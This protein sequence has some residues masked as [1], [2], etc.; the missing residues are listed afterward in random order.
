M[1]RGSAIN[2]LVSHTTGGVP[3][4]QRERIGPVP[5]GVH[6]HGGDV[7]EDSLNTSGSR[8][9]FDLHGNDSRI[10]R[11]KVVVVEG[12]GVASTKL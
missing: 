5:F 9:V 11:S 10:E 6:N 4:H 1:D 2:Q 12:I 7:R 8:Q 3:V